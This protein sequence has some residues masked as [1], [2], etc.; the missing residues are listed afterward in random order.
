[1]YLNKDI[2]PTQD[3]KSTPVLK[4]PIVVTNFKLRFYMN[5]IIEKLKMQPSLSIFCIKSATHPS[6]KISGKLYLLSSVRCKY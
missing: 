3:L 2:F 5:F 1:M 6:R 4:K